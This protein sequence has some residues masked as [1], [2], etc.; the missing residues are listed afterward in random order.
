MDKDLIELVKIGNFELI[1]ICIVEKIGVV[2]VYV[3]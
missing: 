3:E 1:Y 2:W